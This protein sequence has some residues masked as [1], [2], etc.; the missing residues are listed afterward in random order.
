MVKGIG[1]E[2]CDSGHEFRIYKR[3]FLIHA[4]IIFMQMRYVFLTGRATIITSSK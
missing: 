4:I 1:D 2:R 3:S